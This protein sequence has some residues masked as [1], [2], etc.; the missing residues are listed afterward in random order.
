[1]KT[2]DKPVKIPKPPKDEE[3]SSPFSLAE[4]NLVTG[5]ACGDLRVM[6]RNDD[7]QADEYLEYT[8]GWKGGSS[9]IDDYYSLQLAEVTGDGYVDLVAAG[10]VMGGRNNDFA[11]QT[12]LE[13]WS[14]DP[15]EET[16]PVFRYVIMND[17]LEWGTRIEVCDI[18]GEGTPDIVLKRRKQI[19][20]FSAEDFDLWWSEAAGP[21]QTFAGMALGNAT[22]DGSR[23]V[24]LGVREYAE[25]SY[26][27]YLRVY[28][29]DN[30]DT[31]EDPSFAI[32]NLG[33]HDS[34]IDCNYL[35]DIRTYDLYGDE[36]LEIL[37]TSQAK[38]YN[39][40]LRKRDYS[41]FTHLHVWHKT[42]DGYKTLTEFAV[43]NLGDYLS[44][45]IFDVGEFEDGTKAVVIG[46]HGSVD[47]VTILGWDNFNIEFIQLDH[48]ATPDVT[49]GTGGAIWAVSLDDADGDGYDEII[50]S[51]WN[52]SGRKNQY[53][54]EVFDGSY[55]GVTSLWNKID[56]TCTWIRT[57]ITN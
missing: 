19:D 43:D 35:E 30:F 42:E 32:V 11:S 21:D 1:M 12:V 54:I 4:H 13:V 29:F 34:M 38:N 39:Y 50:L 5:D 3:P 52:A 49:G 18:D 55:G 10:V 25:A 28:N 41:F 16:N 23:E 40:P 48:G 8:E 56:Q 37:S 14:G 26:Y 31:E 6:H 15:N 33:P 27:G 51:G 24:I 57:H 20:I 7:P 46:S 44:I 2:Q 17:W 47:S 45:A 36:T 9:D 53:Y 22:G